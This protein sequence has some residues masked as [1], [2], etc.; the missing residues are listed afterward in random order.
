MR[1]YEREIVRSFVRPFF[2]PVNPEKWVFPIGCYNSGTTITQALLAAHPEISSLPKE[3]ARFTSMLPAPEDLGWV[4]M[5]IRCQEHMEMGSETDPRKAARVRRDWAPW[6]DRTCRAFM[7]KSISNVTRVGWLENNFDNAY[8]IGI[9]RDGYCV[10][11]GIRRKG[12]PRGAPAKEIGNTYP[13]EMAGEQWVAANERILEAAQLVERFMM[14]KYE[15]LVDNPVETLAAIWV[16]LG[17][18]APSVEVLPTGLRI[19]GQAFHLEK[20]NDAQSHSRLSGEDIKRL[21][22]V[23]GEM[24]KRLGYLLVK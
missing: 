14:I 7:D 17:L 3:G 11:E 1:L 22:P 4:R 13:I 15:E 23:I 20:N 16:F 21:T 2:Q 19:N 24:Q 5:W 12:H 10:S 9:V 8:F 18:P 6:L